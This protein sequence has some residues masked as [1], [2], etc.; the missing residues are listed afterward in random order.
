MASSYT[1]GT[2]GLDGRENFFTEEADKP[3]H[4]LFREVVESLLLK[5]SRTWVDVALVD[6]F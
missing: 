4:R 3:W 2:L 6:M 5:R 1:R